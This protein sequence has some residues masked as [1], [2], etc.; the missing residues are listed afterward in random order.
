[1]RGPL[2][3]NPTHPQKKIDYMDLPLPIKYEEIQRE[4]LSASRLLQRKID[5]VCCFLYRLCY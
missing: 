5:I 3:L 4:A 2:T 1:M